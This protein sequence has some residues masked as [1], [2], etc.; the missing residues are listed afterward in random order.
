V[1]LFFAVDKEQ[2]ENFRGKVIDYDGDGF[3]FASDH[4]RD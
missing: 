1:D 4:G 3:V 2:A